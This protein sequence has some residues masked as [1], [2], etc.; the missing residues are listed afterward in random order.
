MRLQAYDELV[1]DVPNCQG[2]RQALLHIA[3]H[4]AAEFLRRLW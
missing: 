2:L 1:L 3:Q 4:L